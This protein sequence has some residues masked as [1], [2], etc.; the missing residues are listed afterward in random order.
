MH[1]ASWEGRAVEERGTAWGSCALDNMVDAVVEFFR[2]CGD[3]ALDI[4]CNESR[5]LEELL[6]CDEGVGGT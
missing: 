2:P 5:E 3:D 1:W 6:R 4:C